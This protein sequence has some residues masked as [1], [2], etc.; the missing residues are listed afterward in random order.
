MDSDTLRKLSVIA[1]AQLG[2]KGKLSAEEKIVWC[3]LV[4]E[5]TTNMSKEDI[6]A[7]FDA[8]RPR[9]KLL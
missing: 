4:E 8:L 2:L 9:L 7:E 3:K 6:V 1:T 5:K